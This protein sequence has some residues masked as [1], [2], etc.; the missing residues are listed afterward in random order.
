MSPIK[1]ILSLIFAVVYVY[2]GYFLDRD[3]FQELVI[4]FGVGFALYLFFVLTTNDKEET[5]RL[6]WISM[7]FRLIFIVAIP[8]LSDDYFR[9]IWDGKLLANGFNP[10]L[11][12]PSEIVD[13]DIAKTAGLTD[14]L[15]KGLN[16][17]E[18]Y[19]VYPPINQLLFSLGG[20]FSKFGLLF[21]IIA[22]RVPILIAEFFTIKYIRRLLDTL[23]LPHY[24]VLLYA[25]NP[26]VIVELSGN[27]HYEGMMLL[28]VVVGVYWLMHNNWG[29]AAFWWAM[30]I[31]IKLIPIL[32]LPVLLKRLGI[33]KSCWFYLLTTIVLAS[34]FLP[35][36]DQKLIEHL[37]SSIDLYFRSFEF[38]ASIYYIIRWLGFKSVGYNI[39][40][41][42]GPILSIV[43][44]VLVLMM[45][46]YK[47]NSWQ[48]VLRKMLFAY[49]IYLLLATTVCPWYIT[50]LVLLSVFVKNY[51]YAIL[52]S[53]LVILSYSAYE[54][55]IVQENYLLI[56]I[57]YVFVIGWFI[58]ELIMKKKDPN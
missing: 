7:L 30:A 2:I 50:N 28:G 40:Q 8:C 29:W 15:Y 25:L 57:E 14:A 51:R 4:L 54:S 39:I 13:T 19:T 5:D 35:F 1:Y 41:Q 46:F 6:L 10:Y 49:T 38:N 45:Y 34:T 56:S 44:F 18:Y 9:F 12:V 53:A 3:N 26:L 21:G 11:F 27:L 24:H 47:T 20:F 16:S 23:K 36:L 31:S 33:V 37:F 48:D 43:T 55:E 17:P 52:W 42:V 58:F 22:I 32:F